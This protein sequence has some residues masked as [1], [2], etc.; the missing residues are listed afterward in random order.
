VQN[1]RN[2]L[3]RKIKV[4]HDDFSHKDLWFYRVTTH[5]VYGKHSAIILPPNTIALRRKLD[6][7][8]VLR[9][10][11]HFCFQFDVRCTPTQP[12]AQ[13]YHSSRKEQKRNTTS[14]HLND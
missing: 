14:P 8:V 4:S 1:E 5:I 3:G 10:E 13:D 6:H 9:D 12:F 7:M 11:T 2:K